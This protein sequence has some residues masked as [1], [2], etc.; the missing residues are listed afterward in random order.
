M[1][2]PLVTSAI[3]RQY[4]RATS[5]ILDGDVWRHGDVSLFDEWCDR[6]QSEAA[7]AIA[8]AKEK[9]DDGTT[10]DVG[11]CLGLCAA[12]EEALTRYRL[13]DAIEYATTRDLAAR[14]LERAGLTI[15][16]WEKARR[17]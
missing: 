16:A 11:V 9:S 17:P 12:A 4:L 1:P 13:G 14:Y 10:F 2:E 8:L 15:E 5:W 6:W 3:L 7:L